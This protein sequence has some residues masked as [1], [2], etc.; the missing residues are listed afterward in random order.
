MYCLTAVGFFLYQTLDAIDGKQARATGMGGPLGQMMDHGCDSLTTF[1]SAFLILSVTRIG[2]GWMSVFV[3]TLAAFQ[4][5]FYSWYEYTFGVF[6]SCSTDYAGVTEGQWI[7]ISLSLLSALR[8][9]FWVSSVGD[10]VRDIFPRLPFLSKVASALTFNLPIRVL[11]YVTC[12][13]GMTRISVRDFKEILTTRRPED[14]YKAMFEWGQLFF[15]LYCNA[16]LILSGVVTRHHF[17]ATTMIAFYGSLVAW[18]LIVSTLSKAPLRI[19]QWQSYPFYAVS[20]LSG[21]GVFTPRYEAWAVNGA[22]LW[23]M[24]ALLRFVLT[25]MFLIRDRLQTRLFTVDPARRPR[26]Q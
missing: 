13:I 4:L 8:P 23:G 16:A 19:V 11:I 17:G 14:F 2:S 15:H 3:V 18:R 12:C 1:Y 7:I 24:Y 6:R 25:N 5:Y 22:A 21:C 10:C 20:M 26:S 9:D